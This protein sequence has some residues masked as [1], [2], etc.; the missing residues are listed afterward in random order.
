MIITPLIA[1]RYRSDGGAMFGLVP[2]PLWSR[3]IEPDENNAIPQNANCLLVEL[4][5][6]RVGLVDTGCGDPAWFS[7]RDRDIKGLDDSWLLPQALSVLSLP[8]ASVDFVVLTH[9]HWDHAGGVG[10]VA[11]EESAALTFPNA[12]IF[13]HGIEWEEA[14]A[15]N[16]L[17]GKSYPA[18]TLEPLRLSL[19]T[20]VLLVTDAA[21]EILPGVRLVRTGGHTAGHCAVVLSSDRMTVRH[22]DAGRIPDLDTVVFAGDACPTQAHL[23]MVFQTSFDTHPLDTRD[24]KRNALAEIAADG[25]LLMYCH[26]P[27]VFGATLRADPEREYVP[28][29]DLPIP[30][31]P[32]EQPS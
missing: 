25:Y 4:D 10:T 26:D 12:Q 16:P 6:G 19:Q 22:P 9:L 1:S 17:L 24:W 14:F 18:D 15:D 29:R 31:P 3:L 30:A 13:I 7:K 21:P 27:S 28:E 2:K 20:Q 11:D 23:R 32:A 5:D 8:A